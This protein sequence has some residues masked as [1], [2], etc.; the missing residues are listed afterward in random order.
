MGLYFRICTKHLDEDV[1][2]TPNLI[3]NP[4]LFCLFFYCC[5]FLWVRACKSD[6]DQ[7]L[8]I[9]RGEGD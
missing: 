2:S 5:C 7:G 6:T 8:N 4:S 9:T 3:G 1:V